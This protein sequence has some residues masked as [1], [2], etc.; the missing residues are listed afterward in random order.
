MNGPFLTLKFQSSLIINH[1]KSALLSPLP[2]LFSASSLFIYTRFSFGRMIDAQV[3]LF[4]LRLDW[5]GLIF[6]GIVC[7]L[8][9]FSF[10][11][12][13]TCVHTSWS[14]RGLKSSLSV[15]L[16]AHSYSDRELHGGLKRLE[17]VQKIMSTNEQKFTFWH[18]I[19]YDLIL[20]WCYG[21]AL[22][23]AWTITWLKQYR[24]SKQRLRANRIFSVN[25]A[26]FKQ[27]LTQKSWKIGAKTI[28][29]RLHTTF[30]VL[31]KKE[32]KWCSAK[33]ERDI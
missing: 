33:K 24:S 26:E 13:G 15:L 28:I 6:N 18:L 29:K 14:K 1:N 7:H 2:L 4:P 5:K 27:I 25:H 21:K 22:H 17:F 16:F 30:S 10:A 31:L 20:K 12:N 23:E 3:W 19:L 8:K 32:N 11:K 9:T